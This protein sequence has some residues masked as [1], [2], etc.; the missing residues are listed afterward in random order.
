[1]SVI[2]TSPKP[3][4]SQTAMTKLKC[5]VGNVMQ[6]LNM[7]QQRVSESLQRSKA[8]ASHQ[9]QVRGC[10]VHH[11]ARPFFTTLSVH[12]YSCISWQ[13]RSPPASYKHASLATAPSSEVTTP[14]RATPTS[15][16]T[17]RFVSFST[18]RQNNQTS[19]SR[20]SDDSD[21]VTDVKRRLQQRKA[22]HLDSILASSPATSQYD[23]LTSPRVATL[24]SSTHA[25]QAF[26]SPFRT[27]VRKQS[28]AENKKDKG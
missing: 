2:S 6:M 3:V 16:V 15:C 28:S 4:T 20:L 24:R 7:A 27:P 21:D 8:P 9:L 12:T 11:H 23:A 14:R 22:A 10:N 13:I 5:R 17:T 26:K 19:T 25:L 18:H 1:M